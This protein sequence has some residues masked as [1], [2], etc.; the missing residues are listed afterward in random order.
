MRADNVV[1]NQLFGV[2]S[3]LGMGIFTFDWVQ[4]AAV[5]EPLVSPW[6]S[7]VNFAG[8]FVLLF[9]IVT[10]ILYYT[11]VSGACMRRG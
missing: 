10:P 5:Y 8:G 6:W 2:S 9:W 1:I 4:I 11:N 7:Q 3:G